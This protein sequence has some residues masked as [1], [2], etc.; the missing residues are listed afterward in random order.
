MCTGNT[1]SAIVKQARETGGSATWPVHV[2]GAGGAD[3]SSLRN[4]VLTVPCRRIV[5]ESAIARGR[6]S[7]NALACRAVEVQFYTI[8]WH[9]SIEVQL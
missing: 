2:A 1:G 7:R 8:Q 5:L 6:S 3:R 9:V 4:S